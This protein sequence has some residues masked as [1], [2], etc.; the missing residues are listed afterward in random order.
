MIESGP[1]AEGEPDLAEALAATFGSMPGLEVP[2]RDEWALSAA[3]A[4]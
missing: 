4:G 2:S 1:L 3:A